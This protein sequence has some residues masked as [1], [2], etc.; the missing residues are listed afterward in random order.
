MMS[1]PNEVN[2]CSPVTVD[3]QNAALRWNFDTCQDWAFS[4]TTTAIL[5]MWFGL[6]METVLIFGLNAD[7][8]FYQLVKAF[9]CNY[10]DH[11]LKIQTK[12]SS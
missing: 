2:S 12:Y 9:I 8:K 10:N 5:G 6:Y 3:L 7:I 4:M 11:F 1:S